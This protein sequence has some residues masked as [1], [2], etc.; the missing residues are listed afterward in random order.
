MKSVNK[1]LI[2][3]IIRVLLTYGTIFYT[4]LP[5]YIKGLS[6]ILYDSFDNG[7]P[8][9]LKIFN[10]KKIKEYQP[11]DKVF[12]LFTSIILFV[13]ILNNKSLSYQEITFIFLLLL[14]RFLGTII[15]I[16]NKK[17][18]TLFYFPNFFLEITIGL[19]F[20]KQY[21][22]FNRYNNIIIFIIFMGKLIQEYSMHYS[23][24][25]RKLL[26]RI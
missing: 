2:S 9:I 24:S 7:I 5:D 13:Y 10:Y 8:N 1:L 25:I 17:R 4:C 18:R 26:E 23:E 15:F 20:L 14:Y 21:P 22:I 12:D 3:F 19:L 16:I 6:I 11:L